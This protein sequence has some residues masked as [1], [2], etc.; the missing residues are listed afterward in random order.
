MNAFSRLQP[1]EEGDVVQIPTKVPH[2]LQHGVRVVEFQTPDY[3]RKIISFAQRVLNQ[4][5]WDSEE[6]LAMMRMDMPA[7]PEAETL[8]TPKES[9]ARLERLASF[10]DFDALR[11]T[12]PPEAEHRLDARDSYQL[13]IGVTGA[14]RIDDLTLTPEKACL[15]SGHGASQAC[16]PDPELEASLLIAPPQQVK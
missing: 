15:L 7:Q 4:S 1:L 6:A 13:L 2:A 8:A 16:N 11:L 10:P 9:R 12:L 5:H 3:E 14:V